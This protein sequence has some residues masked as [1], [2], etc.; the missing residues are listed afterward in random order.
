MNKAIN[1]FLYIYS[2]T[3]CPARVRHSY[4]RFRRPPISGKRKKPYIGGDEREQAMMTRIQTTAQSRVTS[5]PRINLM[6]ERVDRVWA[7]P[8]LHPRKGIAR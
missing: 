3:L 5:D 1:T 6:G 4:P 7:D 8:I 2:D